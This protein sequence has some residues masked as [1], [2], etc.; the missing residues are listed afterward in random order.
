MGLASC[1]LCPWACKAGPGDRPSAHS[2]GR[3]AGAGEGAGALL[4][5]TLGEGICA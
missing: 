1:L 3:G 5:F 2:V 4:S